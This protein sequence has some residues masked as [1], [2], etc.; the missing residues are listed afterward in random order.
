MRILILC[1]D[2]DNDLG[3]KT[4]ISSPVIGRKKNLEAAEQLALVDPEESD[5]NC[6]FSAISTFDNLKDKDS[7]IVTLCGD[8]EIGPQSDQILSDQL[9]QVIETYKPA[10]VILVTDGAEDEYIVPLVESR[11]KI[12][13]VKRTVV[14]QSK[15]LEGTYYLL[16]RFLEDEKMQ[17]KFVL[18]LSLILVIWGFFAIIGSSVGFAA[19]LLILGIYL[20]GR[21]FHLEWVAKRIGNEVSAGLKSGKITLFANFLALFVLIGAFLN[22]YNITHS[23]SSGT[24]FEYILLFLDNVVWWVVVAILIS[25][26]GRFTDVYLRQKTILWNYSILLFSL[27]AFGLLTSAMID[28]LIKLSQASTVATLL[29]PLIFMK[30][31]GGIV[32][33]FIGM[34]LYHRMEEYYAEGDIQAEI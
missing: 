15:G 25:A 1:I 23:V 8:I 9:D 27:P 29:T 33:A 14:R 12:N 10:G 22:A 3:R 28:V 6:M 17:K 7:E 31:V 34:I 11:V 32:A 21:V 16:A 13:S 20:L 4:S 19:V 2:R 24:A 26:A 5:V 18:P 30:I